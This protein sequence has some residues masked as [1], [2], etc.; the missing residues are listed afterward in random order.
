MLFK[1][2]LYQL[3]GRTS[4]LIFGLASVPIFLHFLG[5]EAYGVVGL[6]LSL[7]ALTGLVDMGV[8][9]SANRQ[10]STLLAQKASVLRISQTVRSLEIFIW[11]V[12]ALLLIGLT[13]SADYLASEWLKT[14]LLSGD[15]VE[16]ALT[17]CAFAIALRFPV[18]FYNNLLFAL[19][20]HASA[21]IVVSIAALFRFLFPVLL[22]LFFSTSLEMF[23]YSQILANVLE[24]FMCAKLVWRDKMRFFCGPASLD[25][26]RPITKMMGSLTGLSITAIALSQLD[27]IVLSKVV[28]L[29]VFGIY[30]A[31]YSI[32]MGLLPIA[33]SIGNASFPEIVKC[34]VRDL[35]SHFQRVLRKSITLIIIL[36]TPIVSC[37]V[38]YSSQLIGFV[39][40]FSDNGA[41]LLTYLGLLTIG[42]FVQCLGVILHSALLAQGKP[43][44]LFLAN[45]LALLTFSLVYIS[46]ARSD[47]VLGVCYTFIALN[48]SIFGAQVYLIL[49]NGSFKEIWVN[50]LGIA[51]RYLIILLTGYYAVTL[52]IPNFN[53]SLVQVAFVLSLFGVLTAM[54]LLFYFRYFKWR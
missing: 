8:P 2:T 52:F 45:F 34:N 6:Y 32:A 44:G 19:D 31:A 46:F 7:V 49:R 26:L 10:I 5:S 35:E 4:S 42:S 30:S 29:D 20:R 15:E 41:L 3:Y 54:Q 9:V 21:N 53:N 27:K 48:L 12:S 33:Y 22:F 23:F 39:E 50:E 40:N 16:A 17:L 37:F 24:V 51:A 25:A 36:T 38:F 1:N 14:V 13:F 18:A 11:T 28:T 47:G 43:T